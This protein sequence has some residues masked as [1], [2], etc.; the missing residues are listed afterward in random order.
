MRTPRQT[1][2]PPPPAPP[3]PADGEGEAPIVK[4][5]HDRISQGRSHFARW[6]RYELPPPDT[7]E[8]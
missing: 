8:K 4:G 2:L 6:A 1:I 5:L 3:D 7:K